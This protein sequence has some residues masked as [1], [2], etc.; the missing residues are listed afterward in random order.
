MG[1]V[2]RLSEKVE[3]QLYNALGIN[4]ELVIDHAWGW[5]PTDIATIKSYRPQSNS[6]GAGQV[7][8]EPYTAEKARLITK[9]MTELLVLDLVKKGLV[10]KKIELTIGYDRTSVTLSYQGRNPKENQYKYSTTGKPYHGT[11]GLDYYGRPCPKHA[12]G[13]GNIDRWTSSTQR[14]I[15][16]MI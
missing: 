12:H 16:V 13:T 7:L 4:A 6:L 1:D 9:E 10:T 8:M 5:E 3:S 15:T 2:A 11:V 14:I